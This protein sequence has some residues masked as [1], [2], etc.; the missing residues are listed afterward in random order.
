MSEDRSRSRKRR[1]SELPAGTEATVLTDVI[2]KSGSQPAIRRWGFVLTLYLLGIFM[3]A[4]DTGIVTPARTI[5]QHDLN[6]SDSLGIWLITIYTLSYAASIPVMGK[7]ADRIG[8]KPVYLVSIVL[9]G[10]GSLAC[11]LSQ[12]TGS[13]AMLIG[14]RAIQAIGG[15]GILPIATAE[16]GTEVPREKRGMA[17]GLV[18]GVYG[19]ANIFGA[20]AGSVILDVAGKANWQWIFYVNVPIA[21]AIVIAGLLVLPNRLERD[22]KPIDLIGIVL[23]VGMILSLLYGLK[24]LDF[25]ALSSSVRSTSVWPYLLG[26]LIAL[27]LFIVAERRATDPVLDLSYFTDRGIGLTLL[28]SALS[29]VIL[30]GVIFVPQLSENAVRIPSGSGGYFVIVLGLASGIG[31][32]MSGRLTDKYGPK[33]ILGLGALVS[34]GA[35][36]AIIWWVLPHPSMTSVI[37]SLAL[38]G[39]GLGFVIGSPLNYMMLERTRP[40]EASSA[41]ASL[42]LVRSI[43]TTVAP[44]IMIGFIAHAGLGMQAALMSQLPTTIST[45]PLPYSQVLTERFAKWKADPNIGPKLTGVTI[46]DLTRTTVDVSSMQG[47]GTMPAD[48]VDLLKTADVTNITE[49]TKTVAQRMFELNTPATV[50]TIQDG[51]AKGIDGLTSGMAEVDKTLADMTSSVAGMDAKLADMDSQLAD[52]TKAIAGMSSGISQM[53]TALAGID[54]GITGMKS[55]VAG[56]TQGIA[57]MDQGLA[58]QKAALAQLQAVP[59]PTLQPQITA[60]TAAIDALQQKRDTAAAQLSSLQAKLA[61]T[62]GQRSQLAAQ[63]A[64]L[65]AQVAGLIKA[66][67]GLTTGR[68]ELAK[69]RTDLSAAKD[70]LQ[71]T[72]DEMADTISKLTELKAAVPGV[73]QQALTTYLAEIDA[74]GPSLQATFQSTLGEGF[75][76]VYL[77]YGAACLL[78]LLV[79]AGTPKS[80][81]PGPDGG[82]EP[83]A[84]SDLAAQHGPAV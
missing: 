3:G 31:A 64:T 47:S 19:I 74:R 26:F 44:A 66:H 27:P 7:M 4:I 28:L 6:V 69:A 81:R 59:D 1:E 39:L 21:I 61:S 16:I 33:V 48:L 40:E 24:N 50:T 84:E 53:G 58:Q 71:A 5:I 68:T 12:D 10:L 20:S 67:D 70:T 56:A 82:S 60:L 25:F 23:L 80:K 43:G 11:G 17:L 22:A 63:R 76:G 8:R 38:V 36:A 18:G 75:K 42:S 45:P 57:G 37:V 41:L 72:R 9:F 52:M 2:P 78:A 35:A 15:G 46:P 13:F 55:G 54:K 73:F 79:L 65:Q 51:V 34:V 62:Q 77:L 14:A 83:G 32:P 49:R 29:G 30:M